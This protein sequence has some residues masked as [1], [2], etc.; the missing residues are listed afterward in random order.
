M[1]TTQNTPT[2]VM[3]KE[4]KLEAAGDAY[5]QQS[6]DLFWKSMSGEITADAFNIRKLELSNEY[7][8]ICAAIEAEYSTNNTTPQ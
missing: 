4:E 6:T 8:A 3:T 2:Q 7:E 5:S 1:N